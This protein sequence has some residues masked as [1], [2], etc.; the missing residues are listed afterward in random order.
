MT[1]HLASP[2]TETDP[3]DASDVTAA[4]QAAAAV[5]ALGAS[6]DEREG[7]IAVVLG[8]RPE[9]IKLAGVIHALG[10]RA[11]VVWT[12]QHYDADLSKN[13]FAHFG[14]ADPHVRIDGVGG[15]HRGAQIGT[16]ISS[17]AHLFAENAPRAVI[18]QGDTNTTSAGAQAAHYCGAKV[19]HVEAGLRSR[20]RAMPEEINRQVVGVL[21]DLHCAATAENADNLIAEG[22]DAHRIMVTGNTVVEAVHESKPSDERAAALLHALGTPDGAFVL[23][24]LHRPE[25]TDD[26][27]R[28][29]AI[30][31]ELGALPVP[32]L[33]P[34]HPRTRARIDAFGVQVAPTV[35]LLPPIDHP[36]FLALAQRADLIVSDSGGV[37]EEVT[38]LKK[39]LVVV[40][41]STE[42]P[43]SVTAGFATLVRP[44][45]EVGDACRRLLADPD[46]P[47]RLAATPSP[48]GDG[49]ASLRIV[50][51]AV[52]L[53]D[54]RDQ[55]LPG[56][57]LPTGGPA[58]PRTE[59]PV[60]V[61]VRAGLRIEA[62]A[63]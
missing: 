30:L 39:P 26:P 48:Y 28:L 6:G 49:L 3:A 41:N 14:L 59:V 58:E 54:G 20:D 36:G 5:A 61:A 15:T 21:S 55:A 62:V 32:V 31:H 19:L 29:G 40:R 38:V 60:A 18:V 47:A 10:R 56:D 16:M 1:S 22:V 43:E 11:R 51:A 52:A 17:M 34:L 57:L 27:R 35:R 23:A 44:G 13:F 42:R 9:I 46:L 45:P 24:T 2:V 7:D 8:T 63:A 53:A 25:N 4:A 12:G 37:Q 50:A 33:M